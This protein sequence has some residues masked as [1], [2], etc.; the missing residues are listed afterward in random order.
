MGSENN[1]EAIDAA[2]NLS[3]NQYAIVARIAP[4]QLMLSMFYC[5]SGRG[6][7]AL[8]A[9]ESDFELFQVG[10]PND[11][12]MIEVSSWFAITVAKIL[13]IPIRWATGTIL[14]A[15]RK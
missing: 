3:G 10:L 14:C 12:W 8:R 5:V 7:G 4:Y 1:I 15:G 11:Q 9:S 2:L 6:S 13:E